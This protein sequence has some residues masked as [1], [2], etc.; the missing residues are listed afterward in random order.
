MLSPNDIAFGDIELKSYKK[1]EDKT[2][3]DNNK[4]SWQKYNFFKSG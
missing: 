4:I 2:T 1:P 3:N